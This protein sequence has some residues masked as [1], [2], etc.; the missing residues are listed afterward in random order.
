MNIRDLRD[1]M[2]KVDVEGEITEVGEPRHVNLRDGGE[3]RTATVVI[4]DSTGSIDLTLWDDKIDEVMVGFK[5]R[6]SNAYT[7]SYRGKLSVDIGKYGKLEVLEAQTKKETPKETHSTPFEPVKG[8]APLTHYYANVKEV[9]ECNMTQANDLIA[10]GWTWEGTK[11][12]ASD[13]VKDGAV[14]HNHGFVYI[15]SRRF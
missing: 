9:R 5:V 15:V 8:N 10:Q 14:I 11:E 6:I 3:A 1:G 4:K 7:K 13:E 2:R 12:R